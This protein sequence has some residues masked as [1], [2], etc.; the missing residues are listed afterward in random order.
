M[1][2]PPIGNKLKPK[3]VRVGYSV[4]RIG[5]GRSIA[6]SRRRERPGERRASAPGVLQTV[7]DEAVL[8]ITSSLSK[9]VASVEY[10]VAV[11]S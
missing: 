5:V 11:R 7:P 8:P 2:P 4:Q 10:H 9:H 1:M 3:A 6:T